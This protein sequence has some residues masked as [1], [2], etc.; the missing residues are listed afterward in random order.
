M[1]SFLFETDI[2]LFICKIVNGSK[3]VRL[4]SETLFLYKIKYYFIDT[5]IIFYAIYIPWIIKA[6]SKMAINDPCVLY[7]YLCVISSFWVWAGPKDLLLKW[8][9]VK[10]TEFHFWDKVTRDISYHTVSCPVK[11]PM[12]KGT[13]F[14]Q[15]SC[16]WT[17]KWILHQ[18]SLDTTAAW[19][20]F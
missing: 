10:T 8:N 18:S 19:L 2:L 5:I 1:N 11:R 12:W 14:C 7:P 16:Q 3:C 6:I 13:D 17:W 20:T 4:P 9:T 15:Q